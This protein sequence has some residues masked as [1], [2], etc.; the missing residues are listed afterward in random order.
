MKRRKLTAKQKLYFAPRKKKKKVLSMARY[1]RTRRYA[2]RARSFGRRS[3]SFGGGGG[4]MTKNVLD[5]AIV[6]IAQSAIPDM[7]P[8]QDPIIALGVGWWRKN[9]TLT[10]LGGLQ[11]GASIG[12]MFGGSTGTG[13]VKSQV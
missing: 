1:R 4:S 6:G 12:G 13:G 3:R 5:G 2:S 11:L 8:M 9:P 7:F 10:T